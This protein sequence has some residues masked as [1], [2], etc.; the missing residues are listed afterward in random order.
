MEMH[1]SRQRRVLKREKKGFKV[2][3]STMKTVPTNLYDI[4]MEGIIIMEEW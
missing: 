1:L 2:S 3:N 4:V